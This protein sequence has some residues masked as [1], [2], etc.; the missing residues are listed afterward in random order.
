MVVVTLECGHKVYF[1]VGDFHLRLN[2]G[3]VRYF[4]DVC[5]MVKTA[6]AID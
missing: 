1:T 3:K 4:C 2:D 5:M 6:T